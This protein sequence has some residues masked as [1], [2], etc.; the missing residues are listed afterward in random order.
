MGIQ[1]ASDCFK[2]LGSSIG[3][4]VDEM[5]CTFKYIHYD[6]VSCDEYVL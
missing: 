2:K 6:S 1:S 5:R 4:N 3:L